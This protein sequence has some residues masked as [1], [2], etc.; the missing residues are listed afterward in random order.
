V[1]EQRSEV[2]V[3]VV[4]SAVGFAGES[5]ERPC[6]NRPSLNRQ[7]ADG[8]DRGRR[9]AAAA[10]IRGTATAASAPP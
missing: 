3:V 9:A 4:V 2:V 6:T 5:R 7:P 1:T 10:S 8:V